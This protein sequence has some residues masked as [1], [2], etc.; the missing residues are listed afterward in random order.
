MMYFNESVLQL[1][2][3]Y[4]NLLKQVQVRLLLQ[5]LTTILVFQNTIFQPAAIRK[6]TKQLNHLRKG[7]INIQ[8]ID[9]YEYFESSIVRYL[10]A[11]TYHPARTEKADKDFAKRILKT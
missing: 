4:K 11:A 2:Q 10:N 6:L 7:L 8:N 5:T 1:Y 9:N 3:T